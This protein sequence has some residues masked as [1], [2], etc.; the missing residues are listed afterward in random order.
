M[1]DDEEEECEEYDSRLH[2][3]FDVSEEYQLYTFMPLSDKEG[4][5]HGEVAA[6]SEEVLFRSISPRV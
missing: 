3:L 6:E 1:A 2:Y 5:A 4:T